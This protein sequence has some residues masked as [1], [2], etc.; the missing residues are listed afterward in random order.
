MG[1]TDGITAQKEHLLEQ[2]APHSNAGQVEPAPKG[3]ICIHP[4]YR[5]SSCVLD[6]RTGSSA[7]LFSEGIVDSTALTRRVRRLEASE[8]PRNRPTPDG[9]PRDTPQGRY[10]YRRRLQST[11]TADTTTV[12]IANVQFNAYGSPSSVAE[13]GVTSITVV[14]TSDG[15]V[16]H[17]V[18][19]LRSECSFEVY[20]SRHAVDFS[21]SNK[22]VW[23]RMGGIT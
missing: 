3:N 17:F 2:G 23:D 8:S 7:V 15:E 20:T 1:A 16:R 4:P 5:L 13:A 11:S 19:S 18:S 14:K 12:T 22:S 6:R 21:T 9:G 10:A